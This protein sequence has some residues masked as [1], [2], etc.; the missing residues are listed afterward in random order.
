MKYLFITLAVATLLQGSVAQAEMEFSCDSEL[1]PEQLQLS[2][3]EFDSSLF[4]NIPVQLRLDP[5]DASLTDIECDLYRAANG[6]NGALC[7]VIDVVSTDTGADTEAGENAVTVTTPA[8]S[9]GDNAVDR[10]V[11][12]PFSTAEGTLSCDV[13]VQGLLEAVAAPF[14]PVETDPQ[15]GRVCVRDVEQGRLV[16]EAVEAVVR[17]EAGVETRTGPLTND[18][19]GC[20]AL[21]PS[22]APGRYEVLSFEVTTSGDATID[23]GRVNDLVQPEQMTAAL[24]GVWFL[25]IGGSGQDLG[26]FDDPFTSYASFN[27]AQ[28]A[29]DGPQAGDFIF[30]FPTIGASEGGPLRLLD[31]QWLIGGSEN[32]AAT[33]Q[34]FGLMPPMDSPILGVEQQG[35]TLLEA[36]EQPVVQLASNNT[37]RGLLL[38][39]AFSVALEGDG[40]GSLS[41]RNLSISSSNG[42][43]VAFANMALD[44]EI[45]DFFGGG[46]I[47]F[48]GIELVNTT[49]RFSASN[50]LIIAVDGQSR[51]GLGRGVS[52]DNVENVLL[53]DLEIEDATNFGVIGQA[54]RNFS[55]VD[56]AVSSSNLANPMETGI[57]LQNVSGDL[58]IARVAVSGSRDFNILIDND[59]G[60]LEADLSDLQLGREDSEVATNL[61]ALS[62][63]GSFTRLH[64]SDS[65]MRGARFNGVDCIVQGSSRFECN[66]TDL[67]IS[68]MRPS[69]FDPVNRRDAVLL[70]SLA[71]LPNFPSSFTFSYK[72]IGT[73][74]RGFLVERSSG[75][76]EPNAVGADFTQGTGRVE[77]HVKNLL[78]GMEDTADESNFTGVGIKVETGEQVSHRLLA[79]H[80]EVF[81]FFADGVVHV[82]AA[83]PSDTTLRDIGY[84]ATFGGIGVRMG[85]INE[86]PDPASPGHC[87]DFEDGR[88]VNWQTGNLVAIFQNNDVP[89]R[90][91]LPGYTGSP[92]GENADPSGAASADVESYL[93]NRGVDLF[94]FNPEIDPFPSVSNV[95][96]L[97]G[98]ASGCQ[99]PSMMAN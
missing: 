10:L 25:K 48:N 63:F 68:R 99:L 69:V 37:L 76:L 54:V 32:L 57:S 81:D 50:G 8:G 9:F 86:S 74:P 47:N 95:V 19:S 77:G 89:G 36:F 64:V 28:G 1:T 78:A 97:R 11:H 39:T 72:I 27:A 38:F 59:Q 82:L 66:L 65:I 2:L 14:L 84:Y 90:F 61:R 73:Q 60:V 93:T 12:F 15:A 23:L 62:R 40:L 80:V 41:A 42:G 18:G 29:F 88:L 46:G 5:I 67:D 75:G 20:F 43:V 52:L 94:S 53:R 96:G 26:T 16:P 56:S 33:L 83:G 49:G 30:A 92:N 22:F 6:M 17:D 34:E 35:P 70:R 31:D 21:D 85:D 98:D 45:E 58:E 4:S 3:L 91:L 51:P 79:E 7:A 13:A 71:D 44:V 24:E 55:L 87:F